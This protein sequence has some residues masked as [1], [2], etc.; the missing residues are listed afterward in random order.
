MGTL[1]P[2]SERIIKLSF[3][4]V[5]IGS[6]FDT[7]I[8]SNGCTQAAIALQGEGVPIDWTVDSAA[9]HDIPFPSAPY[10]AAVTVHN[11]MTLPITLISANADSSEF[12]IS[13]LQF[14]LS[15]PA[16]STAKITVNYTPAFANEQLTTELYVQSAE[17][18]TQ[19]SL[20]RVTSSASVDVQSQNQFSFSIER[21]SLSVR[22]DGSEPIRVDIINI[23][24]QKVMS[25]RVFGTETF[26]L[27]SLAP[28]IYFISDG[29]NHAKFL[30]Q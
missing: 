27:S 5:R 26:D 12:T 21:N 17:A 16:S 19:S 15:V 24:G 10:G 3:D 20:L 18:G 4:S 22:S 8:I 25:L 28:G 7:V 9:W 13:A 11:N 2:D 14:P 6:V 1:L 23:L 29:T 30:K